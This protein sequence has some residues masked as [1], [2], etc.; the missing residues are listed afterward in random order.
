PMGWLAACALEPDRVTACFSD[1]DWKRCPTQV[2]EKLWGSDFAGLARRLNRRWQ[3]PSWLAAVTGNL[4]LSGEIAQRLGAD[5]ALF[6][7]VQLA[8]LLCQEQGEGLAMSV[9]DQARNL[10]HALGISTEGLAHV[11]NEI[12]QSEG[13]CEESEEWTSPY[14][15][16]LLGDLL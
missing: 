8:V 1:L 9:G 4:G 3:L 14:K 2:Q 7:V 11:R 16:P 15:A 5:L 10:A 6:Q 12:T 13:D